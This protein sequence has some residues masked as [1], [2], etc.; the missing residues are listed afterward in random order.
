MDWIHLSRL[1]AED[2]LSLSVIGALVTTVGTLLGLFLKEVLF[3]RSFETWKGKRNLQDLYR[4]YRDPIA[5]AALDLCSRLIEICADVPTDYLNATLLETRS[6]QENPDFAR[7]EHYKRYKLLSSVYRVCAFLAWVELYRQEIVFL[8]SSEEAASQR[9][10]TAVYAIRADLA[11]GHN[12]ATDRPAWRDAQLFREEQRGI[13][14]AMISFKG[15][16]RVVIG[17]GGFCDLIEANSPSKRAHW[18]KLSANFL[19]DLKPEKDFRLIRMKRLVVHLVDLVILLAPSRLRDD[20]LR[21]R[22]LYLE[23]AQ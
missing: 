15:E 13:G 23:L 8:D 11:D 5:L 7:D 1:R 19:I 18:I 6:Y 22:S 10:T 20:H 4:R 14:E 9:L 21:G 3:A 16:S 12:D 2:I 17:Y